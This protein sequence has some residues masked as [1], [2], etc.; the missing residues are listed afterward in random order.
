MTQRRVLRIPRKSPTVTALSKDSTRFLKCPTLQQHSYKFNIHM[1]R[2]N[3]LGWLQ[4]S[5][6]GQNLEVSSCSG[7]NTRISCFGPIRCY[8][9]NTTMN[10]I[11]F[12]CL[13]PF[14]SHR[15]QPHKTKEHTAA[16][17]TNAK[18]SNCL[19]WLSTR[20]LARSAKPSAVGFTVTL[21]RPALRGHVDRRSKVTS[22]TLQ[23]LIAGIAIMLFGHNHCEVFPIELPMV[24]YKSV[25]N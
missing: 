11:F 13:R 4:P 8:H 21:W 5:R 2:E 6:S 22:K 12:P 1:I 25:H 17:S 7:S 9:T 19:V 24:F 10:P 23:Y 15:F 18:L 20:L 3:N 16:I 14:W